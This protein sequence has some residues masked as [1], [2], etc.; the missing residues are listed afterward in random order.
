MQTI[1]LRDLEGHL[2]ETLEAAGQNETFVVA[3]DGKPW[4]YVTTNS[5]EQEVDSAPAWIEPTMDELK[6]NFDEAVFAYRTGFMKGQ[7]SIPDDFDTMGQAEIEEMLLK[8]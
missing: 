4:M 3:R 8:G 7:F 2:A 6:A 5:I 1:E